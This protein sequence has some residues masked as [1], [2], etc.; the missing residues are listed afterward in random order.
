MVA[1]HV[2]KDRPPGKSKAAH[3]QRQPEATSKTP[4]L[5]IR[6][7]AQCNYRSHP[8]RCSGEPK[9]QS[10]L[11]QLR[12]PKHIETWLMGRKLLQQHSSNDGQATRACNI[13]FTTAAWHAPAKL[14]HPTMCRA[15]SDIQTRQQTHVS[16]ETIVQTIFETI[17]CSG[18]SRP[19]IVPTSKYVSS[20][21]LQVV[22]FLVE[23]KVTS[24]PDTCL[25]Q[26]GAPCCNGDCCIVRSRL[27][28]KSCKSS[29]KSESPSQTA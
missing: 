29:C 24:S 28:R 19:C 1:A 27:C 14:C 6:R 15:D 10:E 4:F 17:C 20:K 7:G 26:S 2:G 8:S 3:V 11:K 16:G 18:I 12:K 9:A 5:A 13:H 23:H 21:L 25:W 22:V